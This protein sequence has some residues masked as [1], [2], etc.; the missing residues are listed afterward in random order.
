MNSKQ[1]RKMVRLTNKICIID[2]A[3]ESLDSYYKLDDLQRKEYNSLI[4]EYIKL[5]KIL[6]GK[7]YFKE[8]NFVENNIEEIF[9]EYCINENNRFTVEQI[10]GLEND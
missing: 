6:R 1:R 4:K 8:T 9:G 3:I 2:N 7:R 10:F 5:D